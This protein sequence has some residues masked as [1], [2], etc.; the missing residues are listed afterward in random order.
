MVRSF[1]VL[2]KYKHI[3]SEKIG[4]G[5]YVLRLQK[6]DLSMRNFAILQF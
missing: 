6:I 2:A 5:S 1:L 4:M 3:Q